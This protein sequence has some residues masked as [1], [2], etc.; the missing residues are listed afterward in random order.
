MRERMDAATTAAVCLNCHRRST[1]TAS[2]LENFDGI[3]AWCTTQ[4]GTRLD[5]SGTLRT[6]SRFNGPAELRE[7]LL[8]TR[9]AYYASMT[10]SLLGYAL[11]REGPAWRIA[12][13]Y[14]MPAVRAVVRAAAPDDYH[15]SALVAGVV[16][17]A[18]FQR[19]DRRA[20][21]ARHGTAIPVSERRLEA[22]ARGTGPGSDEQVTGLAVAPPLRNRYSSCS[23]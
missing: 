14:E 6:A 13:E 3:G 9:D 12:N 11:G 21:T 5:V 18:P 4:D 1:S 17:S 20:R 8:R 7:G 16:K 23:D 22:H 15:W 19:G 2:P 10:R